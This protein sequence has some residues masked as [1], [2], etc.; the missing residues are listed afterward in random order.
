MEDNVWRP[1]H[2]TA[3]QMEE[4]CLTATVLLRQGQLSQS[5]IAPRLGVGRASVCR[6][7]ATLAQEGPCGPEAR[8]I[9]GPSPRLDKK[10]W[11][12]LGWLLDRGAMAA[13]FATER[14]TLERIAA[15]IGWEFGGTII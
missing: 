1:A 2:Q 11:A 3:E 10:A 4:R 15:V 13:G 14:W 6:W 5:E 12:R 7:V 9:P 8:P